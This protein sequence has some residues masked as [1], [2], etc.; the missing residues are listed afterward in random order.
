M[1]VGVPEGRS[2]SINN[3][4]LPFQQYSP[5]ASR[6]LLYPA[7]VAFMESNS[8]RR[9]L[10]SQEQNTRRAFGVHSSVMGADSFPAWRIQSSQE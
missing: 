1:E 6:T 7:E 3:G 2:E 5:G 8:P 10:A 9:G 4:Q